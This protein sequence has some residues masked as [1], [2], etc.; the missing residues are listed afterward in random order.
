[1]SEVPVALAVEDLHKRFGALE[2][3]KGISMNAREHDVVSVI[4][5]SGSGKSTLLRCI[6]FLE[7]PDSGRVILGGEEVSVRTDRAGRPVAARHGLSELQPV[8]PHDGVAECHGRP[9]A[10]AEAAEAGGARARHG[11]TGEGRYRREARCVPERVVRWPAAAGRHCPGA[12]H[13]AQGD[14]LR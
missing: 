7:T 8:E 12:L 14:A 6:N 10:R 11:V 9:P 13:G 1:M 5:S 4:G 3:L 2:V